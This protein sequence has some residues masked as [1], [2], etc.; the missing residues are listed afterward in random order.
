FYNNYSV[1]YGSL[2]A[3]SILM[4]WFYMTGLTILFGGEV[5]AIIEQAA[6]GTGDPES[7]APREKLADESAKVRS[8]GA[9]ST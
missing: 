3:V 1:V 8:A 2:G 7:K 9:Q 6:A 5:N 4:L